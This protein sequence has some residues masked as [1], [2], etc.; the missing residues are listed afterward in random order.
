[1]S[2]YNIFFSIEIMYLYII[3]LKFKLPSNRIQ[4]TYIRT[5]IIYLTYFLFTTVVYYI[6]DFFV[7]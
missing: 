2:R 4:I 1:M 7:S 6:D 3:I 5:H